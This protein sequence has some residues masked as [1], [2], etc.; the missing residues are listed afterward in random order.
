MGLVFKKLPLDHCDRLRLSICKIYNETD[1]DGFMFDF[2][3]TFSEDTSFRSLFE[4][5]ED[6][7]NGYIVSTMYGK[8]LEVLL[9]T[10]FVLIFTNEDI[11]HFH[12]YLSFD[13]WVAY[14]IRDSELFEIKKTSDFSPHNL[15]DRYKALE[16]V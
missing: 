9:N 13:R 10:V 4:L 15:N 16:K 8:P 5:V 11:S 7:K 3:R 6:V 2:T 14:G 1:V 12:H